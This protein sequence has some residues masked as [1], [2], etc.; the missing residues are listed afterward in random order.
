[1]FHFWLAI[2]LSFFL[3]A[4]LSLRGFIPVTRLTGRGSVPSLSQ[5]KSIKF[6][7][8]NQGIDPEMNPTA[9]RLFVN[10]GNIGFE[11]VEDIDPTQV[12]TL[13]DEDLKESADP[14][15]LKYVKFQRVKTLT[16]F[17]EDNN[18]GDVSALGAMK[19]MGRT[20]ATTNM[21]EFK[22]NPNQG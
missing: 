18:G 11:D 19:L 22:K 8:F 10:R 12:I 5:I 13:T 17:I 7:E 3:Y 15:M 9:I 16:I 6:T 21:S 14:I 2:W 20:V 1:M 4:E